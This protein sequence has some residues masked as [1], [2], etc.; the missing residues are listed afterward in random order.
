[1][2]KVMVKVVVM[3]LGWWWW[4]PGRALTHSLTPVAFVPSQYNIHQ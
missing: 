2:V 1:M 4:W 3:V